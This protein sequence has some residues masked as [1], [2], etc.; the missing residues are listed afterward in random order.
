MNIDDFGPSDIDACPIFDDF[1]VR[2]HA[3]GSRPI[4][5]HDDTKSAISGADFGVVICDWVTEA[6]KL[7]TNA[8]LKYSREYVF[9]DTGDLGPVLFVAFRATDLWKHPVRSSQI[10]NSLFDQPI[11][12]S[13][14]A[15]LEKPSAKIKKG[16]EL[17]VFQSGGFSIIVAYQ[18]NDGRSNLIRSS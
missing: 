17:G 8:K 14:Y 18:A 3:P 12:D 10:P 13:F 11:F 6:K 2:R 5:E 7:W 9:I 1:F 15:S 16:D 4:F